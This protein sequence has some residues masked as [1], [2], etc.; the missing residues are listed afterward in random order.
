M[1]T[2][3]AASSTS[4]STPRT[5]S[6]RSSTTP[7]AE[8]SR[9]RALRTC[10]VLRATAAVWYA[11]TALEGGQI[12]RKR[13]EEGIQHASI[14]VALVTAD[15]LS[16]APCFGELIRFQGRIEEGNQPE[17]LLLPLLCIPQ[18]TVS[19]NPDF[20]P[21]FKDFQSIDLTTRFIDG[22]MLLVGRVQARMV[23]ILKDVDSKQPTHAKGEIVPPSS[24][25]KI[26]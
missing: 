25:G 18:E 12:W 17:L 11:P 24:S 2:P 1:R 8:S 23:D 15:Y 14:F 13:I 21:I 3:T 4:R 6:R 9:E 16:S 22:L 20:G 10:G 7:A 19:A 5:G 26:A